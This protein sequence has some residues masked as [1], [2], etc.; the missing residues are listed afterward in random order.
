MKDNCITCKHHYSKECY[1]CYDYNKWSCDF[2]KVISAIMFGCG[3]GG[4]IAYIVYVTFGA[5]AI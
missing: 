2:V 1:D 5:N 4:V 3:M